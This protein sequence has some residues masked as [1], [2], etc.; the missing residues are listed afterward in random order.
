[1]PMKVIEDGVICIDCAWV[2]AN[3]ECGCEGPC[4]HGVGLPV[5]MTVLSDKRHEF[6]KPFNPCPGCGTT[7]AGTWRGYTI[8]GSA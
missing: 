3:G 8:L 7:D 5:G 6:Y 1:M 4:D 2:V